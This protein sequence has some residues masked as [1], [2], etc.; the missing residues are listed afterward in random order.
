MGKQ[1]TEIYAF[2]QKEGGL[3]ARMR[4]TVMTGRTSQKALAFRDTE[5]LSAKF[6]ASYRE[7]TFKECSLEP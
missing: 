3:R 7:I 6:Y 2:I 4:L 5:E 1:L